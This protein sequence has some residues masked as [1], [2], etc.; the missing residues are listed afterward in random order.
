MSNE[1]SKIRK[2]EIKR[3]D[4]QGSYS[5]LL[6]IRKDILSDV[7]LGTDVISKIS[8]DFELC[9]NHLENSIISLLKKDL[10]SDMG[11]LSNLF[12]TLQPS[13]VRPDPSVANALCVPQVARKNIRIVKINSRICACKRNA[14]CMC[15]RH[16]L[17]QRFRVNLSAKY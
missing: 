13:E 5:E 10:I 16:D 9:M 4:D 12:R 6:C 11:S 14:A 15:K 8:D 1:I 17:T 3:I 2:P 7:I